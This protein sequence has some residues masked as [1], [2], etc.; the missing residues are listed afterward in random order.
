LVKFVKN[1]WSKSLGPVVALSLL[2][3][4]A[5]AAEPPTTSAAPEPE[6]APAPVAPAP[7]KTDA[8]NQARDARLKALQEQ[9]ASLS[10]RLDEEQKAR[11][12]A[13][14]PIKPA[15]PAHAEK[16][17]YDSIKL[18]GYAQA[19]LEFHQDSEDQLATGGQ[20]LNQ[21][22][23]VLRR[24]R[25]KVESHHRY[26]EFLLELD[27]NTVRG[28]AFSLFRAELG[29]VYRGSGAG[30]DKAPLVGLSAGIL[31][32]PFGRELQESARTRPFMER[33]LL[34]RAF[35]P[36]E[37]D[38]GAK[39]AGTLG[40]FNYG[41]AV[42]NGEPAGQ[43]VGFPLRDPNSAKDVVG[44]LG[45]AAEVSSVVKAAGGVSMITGTSTLRG[46]DG[47]K[48]AVT[49]TDGNEDGIVSPVELSSTPGTAP[50]QS[51]NFEH[52]AL[53]A[54]I[55]VGVKTPLGQTELQAEL[56]VADN[57]DRS[58]FVSDP[59]TSGHDERQ[60]G[61]Y[62]AV[63]QD[64]TRHALVG[65]RYDYYDPR[66]DV[67]GN[68]NGKFVPLKASVKTFSPLIGARLPA[69]LKL[70]GQW[71]IVRDHMATDVRGVP[72]DRKNN[73]V[74]LRLQGEL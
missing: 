45:V 10:A 48:A 62:V 46:T 18:S 8:G 52:W 67:F 34:S 35:F 13:V 40:F 24:G 4:T 23:F 56:V 69:G 2:S 47:T 44:R 7:A 60:L 68:K 26:A 58:L 70:F 27:G 42:M 29:A 49:W 12:A 11:A 38:L 57:L 71:D 32:P 53:G 39:L 63:L 30:V 16:P 3:Q 36:S 55:D 6:S 64:V 37:P 74:T 25:V 41:V 33:S 20:P 21:N 9:L 59:V 5:A 28:P 51:R 31:L 66:A 50:T 43:T 61:Y 65:F 54:D 1:V 22:R 15:Q 17:W 14:A 73:A 19:Q 72:A